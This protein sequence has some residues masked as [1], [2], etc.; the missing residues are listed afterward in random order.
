MM[1]NRHSSGEERTAK[2][3]EEVR[4]ANGGIPLLTDFCLAMR[5]D[6]VGMIRGLGAVVTC[7]YRPVVTYAFPDPLVAAY[8]HSV[9]HVSLISVLDGMALNWYRQE[10]LI[11]RMSETV[12]FGKIKDP[13]LIVLIFRGQLHCRMGGKREGIEP[14]PATEVQLGGGG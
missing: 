1:Q 8:Q 7:I 13:E 3:G 4:D 5:S 10:V 12:L 9:V 2:T 11:A 6:P 14:C